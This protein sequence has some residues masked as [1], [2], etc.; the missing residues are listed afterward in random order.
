MEALSCVERP[1]ETIDDLQYRFAVIAKRMVKDSVMSEKLRIASL[2][3]SVQAIIL[4]V[5]DTVVFSARSNDEVARRM[6][7]PAL[8]H[9]RRTHF[10][11]TIPIS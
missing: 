10:S 6:T 9:A 5:T 11:N 4:K 8:T 7:G 3:A 2:D 1:L